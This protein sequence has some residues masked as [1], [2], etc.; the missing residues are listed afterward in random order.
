MNTIIDPS[1]LMPI[2]T[3]MIVYTPSS[4]TLTPDQR[5]NLLF[6]VNQP[7]ELSMQEF[8]TGW[9]P[10]VSN[11]WTGFNHKKK[12]NVLRFETEAKVRIERFKDSPNHSHTLEDSE[13]IKRSQ[14]IRS[15]VEQEALKDYHPPAILNAVKEYAQE[16]LNLNESVKELKRKEVTNIKYKEQKYK[17]ERYSI[18]HNSSHGL[19][20]I[21]QSQ[22]KNLEK[23]GWLTL[24]DSTHKT[25]K[26]D[27]C[28]FTLYI[29]NG[30]RCWDIRAHF[31]VNKEDSI[32]V[33]EALKRIRRFAQHWKPSIEESSVRIAFPG[34]EN[35]EQECAVIYCTVHLARTWMSRI[36]D[37]N[38]RQK[39]MRAVYKRTRI[40]CEALIQQAIN[41][42]PVPAIK[43]YISKK[44]A[45]NSHQ[46]ALW[47]RMYSP[48]LLQVTSTN[49]L[50]SYHSELKR[51]TSQTYG[52][53]EA[54][55]K[56]AA[57]DQKK[58]TDSEYISFEFCIKKIS[59]AGVDHEI[60]DELHKFTYP[61]Q[62][63][64]ADEACAVE[65]RIEK[66]MYGTTKLLTN[67]TW[68][69]FQQMFE[70]SG[71]DVYMHREVVEVNILERSKAERASESQRLIVN[72]LMERTRDVYWRIEEEGNENQTGAFIRNLKSCLEPILHNATGRTT[73]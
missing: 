72:E 36:Y 60:L 53:I 33:A 15:L 71:F 69:I 11:V 26:Y 46:W 19:I 64:L 42:C 28:L 61:I 35:D 10:L 63:L 23:F 16:T 9:W 44:Y 27:Y 21:N 4:E 56:V 62:Q 32:T 47:V 12:V 58:H 50:E 54:C 25:N 57:L 20:F 6:N 49:S 38:T 43:Q 24:I 65:K 40:G 52:L 59:V 67:N 41:E 39:M 18:S 1:I 73:A 51:T 13:K 22:I 14:A 68:R 37:N 3:N 31:F 7:I 48:L 34:L 70:E 45:K 2:D 55:I 17:V 29:R 30:Y 5:R 66:H 8:D